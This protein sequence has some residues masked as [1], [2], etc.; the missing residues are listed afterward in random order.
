MENKNSSKNVEFKQI[1]IKEMFTNLSIKDKLLLIA[2]I[3]CSILSAIGWPAFTIINGKVIDIFVQFESNYNKNQSNIERNQFMDH[4]FLYSGL[5]L[6]DSLLYMASMYGTLYF[7]QM[8]ALRRVDAIKRQYVKAI[9]RQEIAWFDSH[10]AGELSSQIANDFKKFET[11][12]N[13]NFGLLMANIA[14]AIVQ[15]SIGLW[16]GWKLSLVILSITPVI[17]ICSAIATKI[18]SIYS[19]KE[20]EAN[21]EANSMTEESIS[22]IRTVVAF[23]GQQKELNK[24]EMKLKDAMRFSYRQS[25]V[26]ALDNGIKWGILYTSLALGVWF[27]VKL[28][29]D[30]EQNYTIGTVVIIFWSITG[31]GYNVAF[32][33]PYI[34]SFQNARTAA[35]RIMSVVKRK[36]TIDS[37][38][39]EGKKLPSNFKADLEFRNINFSYPSRIEIEVLKDF[40]LKVKSGQTIALVGSSGCGKSTIIELIQRFYD[41][42]SGN[43]QLDGVDI[44]E[45]NIGWLREQISV[46]GQEPVLFDTSIEENIRLGVQS[47]QIDSITQDDIVKAA[48]EANAHEFIESLPDG[49]K[50]FVGDRGMQLSGGQKQRI[51]I[52]RAL[53]SKPRILLLDEATSALDLQSEQLVQSALEK[54]SKGRTTII[55]AHRLSTIKN[56]DQIILIDDGKVSEMGTHQELMQQQS[57]Y[58][59]MVMNQNGHNLSNETCFD[60]E[61]EMKNSKKIDQIENQ[62]IQNN[63]DDQTEAIDTQHRRLLSIIWHIN[64]LYFMVAFAAAFLYGL[65]TPTYALIFGSLV[66]LFGQSDDPKYLWSETISHLTGLR[67]AMLCQA[68]STI[69]ASLFIVQNFIRDKVRQDGETAQILGKLIIEIVNSI[70]TVTSLHK[71]NYFIQ[72]LDQALRRHYQV[73]HSH[74]AGKA[75]LIAISQGITFMAYAACYCFGGYLIYQHQITSSQFFRITESMVFGA[76]VVGRTAVFSADYTKAKIAAKNIFKLID[77]KSKV[78]IKRILNN[79]K[80]TNGNISFDCVQFQYPNREKSMVLNG[81]TF[82]ANKGEIVALVGSSGCGKSTTIQLLEQFYKCTMFR[83][84]QH[85]H[86]DVEWVRSQMALVQQEPTLFS[87]SIADNIAYG[88]NG[89]IVSFDEIVRAAQMANVHDFVMSLPQG[90]DTSVGS[91][92]TQLSG[93]QKQRIAIARALIRNPSILLLD[94]ATSALDTAS[95]MIVQQALE[96]AAKGRTCLLVAHRLNTIVHANRIVVIHNGKNVEQGT[97]QQLINLKGHYWQLYNN[98]ITETHDN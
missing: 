85:F 90:Y 17:Y 55:V 53:I 63:S 70:K 48:K 67:I 75:A 22:A 23:Q 11:G 32:A 89:R 16:N 3:F 57:V 64:P 76:T 35:T 81:L 47:D 38:S 12:L 19:A 25:F 6:S 37:N 82:E 54:A 8:F 7:F 52:A 71:Q 44:K 66:G 49:Y 50:T 73:V 94:E 27:G 58:Y 95:E 21:S 65:A 41:P 28:L 91:K 68:L 24:Y 42:N 36:S 4:V 84:N 43:V 29:L 5:Q 15:L 1:S 2:A 40:N 93:G 39:N 61:S 56:A 30:G 60:N 96:E 34:E 97:H 83:R 46:V 62:N 26:S 80:Q 10:S 45:L 88:V 87:Y 86:L 59:E 31:F 92:G 79:S 77:E 18:N 69:I 51:A 9:L 98:A 72:T 74:V 33:S 14:G 20:M 13:E 78:M